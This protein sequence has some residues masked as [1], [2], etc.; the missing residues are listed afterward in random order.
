MKQWISNPGSSQSEVLSNPIYL[1]ARGIAGRYVKELT[2]NCQGI[3]ELLGVAAAADFAQD[4]IGSE[5]GFQQSQPSTPEIAPHRLR[6]GEVLVSSCASSNQG[7]PRTSP[8]I[9]QELTSVEGSSNNFYQSLLAAAYEAESER[10][11]ALVSSGLD[12]QR[13]RP[14]AVGIGTSGQ[15]QHL[16]LQEVEQRSQQQQQQQQQQQRQRRSRLHQWKM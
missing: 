1:L 10:F 12:A 2:G 3:A 16:L 4:G 8:N 5:L 6:P 11:V 9:S 15:S 7:S 13:P 14:E